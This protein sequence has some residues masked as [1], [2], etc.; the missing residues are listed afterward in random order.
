MK[1]LCKDRNISLLFAFFFGLA[2]YGFSRSYFGLF[3]VFARHITFLTHIHGISI[4]CWMIILI[5]QPLLIRFRKQKLHVLIGQWSYAYVSFLVVIMILII[6]QGYLNGLGKLQQS[7]LLAFQFIPVSAFICFILSYI[8]AIFNRSRRDTHRSYMIVHALGLLW[9]AF[10]RLDYHWIGVQTF[11]QSIAVSY[12]PSAFLLV[13]ILM[14][15]LMLKKKLNRVYL[16]ASGL[17]FATPAFYYFA[18]DGFLWQGIA[19]AIF[20]FF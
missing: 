5:I 15:D 2:I 18:A 16:I 12:L 3:P 8:L 1:L 14:Y 20:R 11:K 13:L 9:A 7:E 4:A 6:R 19:K 17:F 10:G